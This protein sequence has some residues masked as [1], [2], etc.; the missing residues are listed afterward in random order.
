VASSQATFDNN[1]YQYD[2]HHYNQG[3]EPYQFLSVWLT[4][5][6]SV[7]VLRFS[8]YVT[9]IGFSNLGFGL[10]NGFYFGFG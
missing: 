7:L 2:Y 4:V 5:S 10:E 6:V 3:Q 9:V 8:V 1:D